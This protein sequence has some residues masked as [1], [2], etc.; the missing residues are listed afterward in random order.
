MVILG[1]NL[2]T[3]KFGKQLKNGGVC[4]YSDNKIKMVIAEERITRIKADCG[5]SKSLYYIMDKL[6]LEKNDIDLV[7]YSS[8]CEN[9]REKHSIKELQ[10]IVAISCGHHLSH[11]LSVYYTSPF[12]KAIILVIDSGGNLLN[13]YE[14]RNWSC[15]KREQHTYYRAEGEKLYL[16]D[17]DFKAPNQAGIGEVYRAFTY[18][19]GW[20]SSRHANKIMALSAL[21]EPDRFKNNNIF[22]LTDDGS[23]VSYIK[24]NP[25]NPLLMV[26]ELL[27][28]YNI[29]IQPRNNSDPIDQDHKDLA[30]WIQQETEKILIEKIN[31]LV[32]N[33]N[34]KNVCLAGG[35]AYNCKAIGRVMRE[36]TADNI[37]IHPA[38]GD[39]GQCLG[40]ALF[41]ITKKLG[42]IDRMYPF[43]PYLGGEEDI[44]HKIITDFIERNG[45]KFELINTNSL[46]DEV[47]NL[48][49]S[50]EFVGIF[51]GRSEYGP[52]A[53]GNRS[54]LASPS[55]KSI[56][57]RLNKMK[58]RNNWMPFAPTVLMKY[59]EKYF[60]I[61]KESPYMTSAFNSTKLS[62]EDDIQAAL[63][64]DGSSRIQTLKREFNPF[65][66][67]LIFRFYKRTKLPMLLNT[68]FNAYN[69]PIVET[70]EDALLTFNKM[71]FN[72]L[73]AGDILLSKMIHKGK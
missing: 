67:D 56:K 1:L 31:M 42:N 15:H 64:F 46:L 50:G 47:V 41:G 26:R 2:G 25:T 45:F 53:L 35:V 52:R 9:I 60:Q 66:F 7:V 23:I 48:L 6:N 14:S 13:N 73:V 16:I 38:S 24:N 49:I 21:G 22:S 12:D 8:C 44:T 69:E 29:D 51:R 17:R 18:Y 65:F 70:L 72:Y 62:K 33:T 43:N 39:Q 4:V 55:I 68:S 37:F 3:T 10:K 19:I 5:F 54:I 61:T 11:A 20:L 63:H 27:D 40:N 59:A 57:I 30:A 71:Q 32:K 36:S 28:S 58:G 34:I